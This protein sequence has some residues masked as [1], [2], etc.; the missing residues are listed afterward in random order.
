MI[1]VE[2]NNRLVRII[3]PKTKDD[4]ASIKLI[5]EFSN[6]LLNGKYP[7][8]AQIDKSNLYELIPFLIVIFFK[9]DIGK[10][11]YSHWKFESNLLIIRLFYKFHKKS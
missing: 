8:N 10:I 4:I 2:K 9:S 5:T 1:E 11:L 6:R 7:N 3:I